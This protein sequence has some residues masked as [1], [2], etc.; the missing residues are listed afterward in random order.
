MKK[1]REREAALPLPLLK[2]DK[3]PLFPNPRLVLLIG[4][5]RLKFA[6]AQHGQSK[7]KK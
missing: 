3:L 4:H 7:E 5:I 1:L 2:G 6:T